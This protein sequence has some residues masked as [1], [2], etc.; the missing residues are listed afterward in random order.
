MANNEDTDKSAAVDDS[1]SVCVDAI[2]PKRAMSPMPPGEDGGG[3]GES[4]F[5][6]VMVHSRESSH[7]MQQLQSQHRQQQEMQDMQMQIQQQQE[8]HANLSP[9]SPVAVATMNQ[10]VSAPTPSPLPLALVT[11][12]LN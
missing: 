9:S 1:S 8:Q 11:A 4:T 10:G 3:Q 5:H 12:N 7:S 6:G 2:P